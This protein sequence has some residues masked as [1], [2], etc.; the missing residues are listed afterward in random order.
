MASETKQEE[1][2]DVVEM[3]W[4]AIPVHRWKNSMLKAPSSSIFSLFEF[5]IKIGCIAIVWKR[6]TLPFFAGK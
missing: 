5:V 2:W 4:A 6:Q 1:L 3:G